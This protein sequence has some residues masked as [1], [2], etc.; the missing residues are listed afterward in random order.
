MCSCQSY[1]DVVYTNINTIL[2]G[3]NTLEYKICE[4][5]DINNYLQSRKLE[6]IISDLYYAFSVLANF[7]HLMQ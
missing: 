3:M 4:L 5:K 6:Q 2:S 7:Y 1:E